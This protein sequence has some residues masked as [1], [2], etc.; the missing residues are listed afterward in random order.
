MWTQSPGGPAPGV[1]ATVPVACRDGWDRFGK[2]IALAGLLLLMAGL[3]CS[4]GMRSGD[5]ASVAP[6]DTAAAVVA[7][8]GDPKPA[9][10]Y[11]VRARYLT[12]LEKMGVGW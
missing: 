10:E 2:P 12:P 5:D 6:K 9:G 4:I 1:L 11:E 3:A 7:G 8:D